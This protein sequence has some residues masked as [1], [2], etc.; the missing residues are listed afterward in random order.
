MMLIVLAEIR[1]GHTSITTGLGLGSA[2]IPTGLGS[3]SIDDYCDACDAC[4]IYHACY[5]SGELGRL[6]ACAIRKNSGPEIRRSDAL[7]QPFL[8]R[9]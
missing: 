1:S 6:N 4:D 5:D 3:G 9:P 8:H 2:S 7:G